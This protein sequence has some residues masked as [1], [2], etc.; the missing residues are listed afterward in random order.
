M[1]LL[2]LAPPPFMRTWKP[3]PLRLSPSRTHERLPSSPVVPATS[4]GT[5]ADFCWPPSHYSSCQTIGPLYSPYS[6][7]LL[8]CYSSFSLSTTFFH[9]PRDY[10]G[11]LILLPRCLYGLLSLSP[12]NRIASS[13]LLHLLAF[14]DSSARATSPPSPSRYLE[15][16][17]PSY[18]PHYSFS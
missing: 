17:I 4:S 15:P 9:P 8:R 6:Y 13:F 5:P 18:Y 7:P 14:Y 11:L 1:G 10:H 2:W 3:P 12:T 16:L